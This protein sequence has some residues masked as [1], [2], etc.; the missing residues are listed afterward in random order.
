MI[1]GYISKQ[2]DVHELSHVRSFTGRRMSR[3]AGRFA[4]VRMPGKCSPGAVC[5][6]W[7]AAGLFW[8]CVA[9]VQMIRRYGRTFG[10]IFLQPLRGTGRV[11][12]I[13]LLSEQN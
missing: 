7:V 10:D 6:N 8:A 12:H 3:L 4:A 2:S 5:G 9:A 1:G 13:V 11:A